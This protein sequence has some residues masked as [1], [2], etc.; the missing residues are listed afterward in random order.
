M[1][2]GN[3]NDAEYLAAL[4]EGPRSTAQL[5]DEMHVTA[6]AV[7]KHIFRLAA[8][9]LVDRMCRPSNTRGRPAFLYHLTEAGRRGPTKVD[10]HAQQADKQ[11]QQDEQDKP[12]RATIWAAPY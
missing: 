6:S 8:A 10:A 11:V 1:S 5:C 3:P 7:R 9:G 12:V 2:K 4:G